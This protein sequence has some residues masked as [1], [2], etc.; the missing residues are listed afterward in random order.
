MVSSRS[1]VLLLFLLV[2]S[3]AFIQPNTI[4]DR[5]KSMILPGGIS[6]DISFRLPVEYVQFRFHPL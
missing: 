6:S 1:V 5:M 3:L 2:V 4:T